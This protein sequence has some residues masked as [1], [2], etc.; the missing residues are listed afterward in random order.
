MRKGKCNNKKTYVDG[1]QFDSGMEANRY[2]ELKVLQQA[3]V[4]REIELQPAFL[5]I[6]KQTHLVDGKRKTER[7]TYYYAD[8]R[9]IYADGRVEV[10]DVKGFKTEVYKIKRK[11]LLWRYPMIT[12]REV[13][14]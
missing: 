9:V 10:E 14:L 4:V 12:F 5:L 6:P 13:R 8:F 1:I 11:L 7:P 2:K 3:G